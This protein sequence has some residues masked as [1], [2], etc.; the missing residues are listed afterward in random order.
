MRHLLLVHP[1][2]TK[3][4]CR[5]LSLL[6]VKI[7]VSLLTYKFFASKHYSQIFFNLL[8]FMMVV[9]WGITKITKVG[10]VFWTTL[11]GQEFW[12]EFW[13]S[14]Y[15]ILFFGFSYFL[16]TFKTCVKILGE[17]LLSISA[18][19]L[20]IIQKFNR[21]SMTLAWRLGRH[22]HPSTSILF[23]IPS[24]SCWNN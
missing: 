22:F 10:A 3:L 20:I 24:S 15:L 7:F 18:S 8:V 6:F 9:V 1:L 21:L 14:I 13:F 16:V 11:L 23:H 5:L 4:D 19:Q 12:I 17:M 2:L